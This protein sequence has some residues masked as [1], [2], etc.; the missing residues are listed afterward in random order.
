MTGHDTDLEP[1]EFDLMPLAGRLAVMNRADAAVP[2]LVADAAAQVADLV[3]RAVAVLRA[4]GRVV[5]LGAGS[6]GRIAALDAAEVGPT[7]GVEG[8]FVAVV[9]GGAA[10]LCDAAEGLEDDEDAAG[11]D[12]DAV[13]LGAGDLLVAVSASGST[14][15]TRAGLAHGR[16]R[17]A[18][19]AAVVC[20][21][22]SPMAREADLAVV[23]PVGPEVVE[24]STRLAAGTAQKL[25]LNQLS[26]LAMVG[27]GHVYGNLMIGVRAENAK[28]RA[29]AR[30]AV[31]S[32]AGLDGS[33]GGDRGDAVDGDAVDAALAGAG[34]EARVA[35]VMLRL[36]VDAQA[37]RARLAAVAG[38]V[39]AALGER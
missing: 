24:G 37:A 36:G 11:A 17:G 33:A 32:A 23:V 18:A 35:V 34:G 31:V 5:Y 15:Y 6:A 26:T 21:A 1:A 16:A 30:R 14:P 13:G 25:V 28:L 22:G 39:R 2:A 7:Y 20:A 19:C 9:A 12:L 27:L 10:A 38:D 29:R 4:G 8:A 3:E